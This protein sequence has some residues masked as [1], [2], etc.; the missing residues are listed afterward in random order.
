MKSSGVPVP[1]ADSARRVRNKN[2]LVT[3]SRDMPWNPYHAL[4]HT[5]SML[6]HLSS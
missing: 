3:F 5:N 2:E 4:L 6:Y 1:T